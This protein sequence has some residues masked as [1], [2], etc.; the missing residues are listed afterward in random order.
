MCTVTEQITLWSPGAH[1]HPRT[2]KQSC[3]PNSEASFIVAYRSLEPWL[4]L[5]FLLV[6]M[7][8]FPENLGALN[9]KVLM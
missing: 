9:L 4:D 7:L 2:S 5:Y 6:L 8:F 1:S 3:R